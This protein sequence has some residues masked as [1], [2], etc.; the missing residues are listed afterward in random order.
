M[1]A[2]KECW[3]KI[4]LIE[5]LKKVKTEKGSNSCFNPALKKTYSIGSS[6]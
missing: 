2:N 1:M 4:M 5:T 3:C 6:K